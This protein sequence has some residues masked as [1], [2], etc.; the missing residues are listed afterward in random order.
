MYVIME[1]IGEDWFT[2]KNEDGSTILF[3]NEEQA[4]SFAKENC[5]DKIG[6]EWGWK[7]MEV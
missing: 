1:K 4:V 6:G 2:V 5:Q 3:E 7:V